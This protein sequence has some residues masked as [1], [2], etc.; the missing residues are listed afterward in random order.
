ME[1]ASS[2]GDV[3]LKEPVGLQPLPLS[4]SLFASFYEVNSS[5]L[6]Y[7]STMMYWATQPQGNRAKRLLTE[8]SK[9]M[10]QD[11]SFLIS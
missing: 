8:S 1:Q 2:L 10:N 11:E 7:T 5:S 6:H 4:L 3:S 9:T